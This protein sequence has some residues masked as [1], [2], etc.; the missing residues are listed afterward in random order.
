MIG[1][2]VSAIAGII[3]AV[4][5]VAGFLILGEAFGNFGDSDRTFA[6]YYERDR[7]FEILGGY[8]LVVSA[9]AFVIFVAGVSAPALTEKTQATAAIAG[10]VSA[11][12][13][14]TLV[15]AAAAAIVTIPASR[16]FGGI[17]DAEGQLAS[18]V[19]A[20][21]QLG[22][23]LLFLPGALFASAT[24]VCLSLVMRGRPD[25]PGWV[26][27]SGFVAAALLLLAGVFFMPLVA[28]PL[29]VL[30]AAVVI[31]RGDAARISAA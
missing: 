7:E 8:L 5:F 31:L 3:F 10:I 28:L 16:F 25:L 27:K 15:S 30:V 22:Y 20:L 26:A 12:V 4:S 21:P 6:Q 11:A 14:A 1:A 19:S 18:E 24:L 9:V 17:F 23:V 29:W 2:R 13:F